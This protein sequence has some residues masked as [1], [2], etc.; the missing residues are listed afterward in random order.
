MWESN[1]VATILTRLT[2]GLPANFWRLWGA[3]LVSNLSDGFFGI[4][5]PLIAVRLTDS[6]LLVAG[7]AVA[8]RVPPLLLALYA[9]A[10]ADR[11]DRR[12]TMIAVQVLRVTVV[13]TMALLSLVGTLTLPVLYGAAFLIGLGE[14]FFDTNAQ[15]LMPSVVERKRLTAANSRLYSAEVAMNSFVGPPLGGLLLS[16]SVPLALSATALGYVLAAVGLVFLVGGFKSARTRRAGVHADIAEGLRYL[17]T[18]RL[19]LALTGMVSLTNLATG[20]FFAV[21]VLYAAAPGPMGLDEAGVGLLFS[22]YAAGSVLGSTVVGRVE[23][24]IGSAR[25]FAISTVGFSV[26]FFVPAATTDAVL[27]GVSFAVA[28]VSAMLWNVTNVSLRQRVI[29]NEL[30]GRVHA[31]HRLFARGSGLTG[32]IAGGLL[33]E[34]VGLPAV[35]ALAGVLTLA[36]LSGLMV[37]SR[38]AIDRAEAAAGLRTDSY[39][40][41]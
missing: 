20:A 17:I 12:Q 13:G 27:V 22:A 11:L 6:P 29:P 33:A 19:L 41:S 5:L 35:F 8:S 1:R 32:A 30:L 3:S 40:S 38:Q 25:I 7:V 18:R 10:L 28:G 37:V 34:A 36:A 2:G 21:F 4:V 14:T 15:S 39:A 9:G 24:R 16:L 31:S 23:P 26:G